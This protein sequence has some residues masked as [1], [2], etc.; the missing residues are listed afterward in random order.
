[1][2]VC[3]LVRVLWHPGDFLFTNHR[4]GGR[5][6]LPG[7]PASC[8]SAYPPEGVHLC[9]GIIAAKISWKISP[10]F[11]DFFQIIDPEN[12]KQILE[13]SLEAK[14]HSRMIAF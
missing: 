12:K 11:G 8:S 3:E 7:W 9:A 13:A 2:G 1:M 14:K 4:I 5:D 6:D 10:D